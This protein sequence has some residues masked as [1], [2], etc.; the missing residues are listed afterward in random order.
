[1]ITELLRRLLGRPMAALL[2]LASSFLA[3]ILAL[4][5]P[6]FVIQVLNRYVT[7]GVDATLTTLAGG[8]LLAILLEQ[9]FRHA[10]LQLLTQRANQRDSQ[11]SE[12]VGGIMAGADSSTLHRIAVEQREAMAQS[13]E[14]I[15][16]GLSANNLASMADL[17][18]SL[19]F[20]LALFLLH[21]LIGSIVA[22]L[23]VLVLLVGYLGSIVQQRSQ[24]ALT[25]ARMRESRFIRFAGRHLESLRLYGTHQRIMQKWLGFVQESSK[26]QRRLNSRQGW[27]TGVQGV[28]QASQTLL[29][30][31]VGAAEVVAGNLDVGTLIGANILAARALQPALKINALI[32]VLNRA[33]EA[34]GQVKNFSR[35]PG[36]SQ[37]GATLKQVTGTLEL[38]DLAFAYPG[39]NVVLFK[40]LNLQLPAGGVLVVT[41]SN[42]S[43]KTTMAR[44]LAGFIT[45]SNGQILLDGVD[46]QQLQRQWW[47]GQL[48]YLPQE[49][50]LMDGTL[51]ENVNP[52]DA[53]A[54]ILAQR[55]NRSDLNRF[56]DQSEQ[57]LEMP[58]R[59][60][61]SNLA[62]G[63]RRRVSLVR[64][65]ASLERAQ[66][67]AGQGGWAIFDEPTEGLDQAGQ[68][69]VLTLL[70]DL[71]QQKHTLVICSS[72]PV[73]IKGA[74]WVLDLDSKP[75]PTLHATRVAKPATQEALL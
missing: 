61:G 46:L 31:S 12:G 64:A 8:T 22:I 9:S 74:D 30:I 72:D 65:L 29:V 35:I 19:L 49:P 14:S 42:G 45:P 53:D 20:L 51:E 5:A 69:A 4:A 1:M 21:P 41:G 32:G 16:Q 58:V 39:Q 37:E 23:F 28:V 36:D 33:S 24:Q 59:D 68:R 63:I 57:G 34:L 13:L 3:S 2:V 71:S 55:V 48:C 47:W 11:I 25:M 60:G 50:A 43:G 26:L 6:L 52:D 40:D 73:L 27:V 10:R 56:V 17:P 15:R 38:R 67:Q 66:S 44:L 62:Y 75:V 7:H 54:D 18:F 70:R